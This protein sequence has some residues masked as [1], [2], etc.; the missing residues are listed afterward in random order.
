[1]G[2]SSLTRDWTW[3]PCIGSVSPWSTR[4]I[5]KLSCLEHISQMKGVL[6]DTVLLN[7]YLHLGRDNEILQTGWLQQQKFIFSPF[8]GW[9]AWGQD[10]GLFGS[11]QELTSWLVDGHLLSESSQAG[12]RETRRG[13][14][15]SPAAA[16]AAKSLQ[17]CPTLCDPMDS[18]PPGSPVPGILQT[19]TLEW[20][21]SL[22]SLLKK[23]LIPSWGRHPYDLM[24]SQRPHLQVP[25][26]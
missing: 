17:S 23:K 8:G 21:S 18:S 9:E 10:A 7:S 5:P 12:N 24:T 2:S 25:F 15:L 1:M 4:E 6:F 14:Q 26:H 3:T 22:L 19:R 13:C 11:W 16:A 20:V